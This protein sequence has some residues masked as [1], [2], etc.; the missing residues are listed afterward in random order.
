C[1][2]LDAAGGPTKRTVFVKSWKKTKGAETDESIAGSRVTI[3]GK[4]WELAA[5]TTAGPLA[6]AWL[7][8]KFA[9][10]D[11]NPLS[12]L[13][14]RRMAVG[15]TWKPDPK[16]AAEIFTKAKGKAPFDLKDVEMEVTLLSAEGAPP[17]AVGK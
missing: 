8:K 1:D 17:D 14:P 7:D 10:D 15:E 9:K 3:D 12:Q 16:I 4:R 11:D 13:A 2:A 6:K 5:G